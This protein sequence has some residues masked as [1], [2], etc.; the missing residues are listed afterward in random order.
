MGITTAKNLFLK[1]ILQGGGS[2]KGEWQ[3][4]MFII[5]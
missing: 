2:T 4:V 3:R 1:T 5:I